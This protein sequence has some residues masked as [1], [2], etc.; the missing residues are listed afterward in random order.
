M[1][2]IE[3]LKMLMRCGVSGN[4]LIEALDDCGMAHAAHT[5]IQQ[6]RQELDEELE[7]LMVLETVR[8]QR[9]GENRK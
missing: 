7:G 6:A 4:E 3:D 8:N 2:V 5:L 9:A 1:S